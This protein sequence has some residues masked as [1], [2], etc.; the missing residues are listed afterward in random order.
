MNDLAIELT[1][2]HLFDTGSKKPYSSTTGYCSHRIGFQCE[3]RRLCGM[4]ILD[5]FQSFGEAIEKSILLRIENIEV[6]ILDRNIK[7]RALLN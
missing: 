2:N 6:F 4:T 5:E 1:V 7:D 3:A